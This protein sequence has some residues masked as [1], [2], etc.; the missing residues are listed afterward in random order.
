LG[1]SWQ[2]KS[3]HQALDIAVKNKHAL[4]R[5]RYRICKFSRGISRSPGHDSVSMVML[6]ECSGEDISLRKEIF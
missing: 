4:T 2:V 1:L 3:F 6:V 5:T